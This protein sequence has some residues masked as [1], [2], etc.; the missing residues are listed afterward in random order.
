[1]KY[2]KWAIKGC[3]ELHA[4]TKQWDIEHP[5]NTIPLNGSYPTWFYYSTDLENPKAWTYFK[6]NIP[7]DFTIITWEML[8]N[9][10]NNKLLSYEIY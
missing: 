2:T 8:N 9:L 7:S 3:P 5:L 10:L 1:M 4:F 6:G